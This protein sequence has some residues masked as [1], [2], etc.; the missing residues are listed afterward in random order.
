MQWH[1]NNTVEIGWSTCVAGCCSLLQ[2]VAMCCSVL[3]CCVV[4]QCCSVPTVPEPKVAHLSTATM[5]TESWSSRVSP[6]KS[7][8]SS[9]SKY[10]GSRTCVRARVCACSC[11]CP[12]AHMCVRGRAH[13]RVYVCL[14]VAVCVSVCVSCKHVFSAH[15]LHARFPGKRYS[16]E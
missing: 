8:S 6:V 2:C 16:R 14:C 13:A 10:A 4:L 3:Q 7:G 12:C 15:R 1:A 9:L 5:R 11:V